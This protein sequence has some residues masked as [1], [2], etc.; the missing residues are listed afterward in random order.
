MVGHLRLRCRCGRALRVA[1][2]RAGTMIRCWDCR[3]TIEAPRPDVRARLADEMREELVA[4]TR[5]PRLIPLLGMAL[6]LAAT[7]TIPRVGPALAAALVIGAVIWARALLRRT[8]GL[9][10]AGTRRYPLTTLG[11]VLVFPLGLVLAEGALVGLTYSQGWLPYMVL[12]LAPRP[13]AEAVFGGRPELTSGNAVD[14]SELPAR[15]ILRVYALG[16]RR[17]HA[18]LGDLPASL[19]HGTTARLDTGYAFLDLFHWQDRVDPTAYLMVRFAYSALILTGVLSLVTLQGRW[20]RRI[21]SVDSRRRAEAMAA[22]EE[23]RRWTELHDWKR[24]PQAPV[25]VFV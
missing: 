1:E 24:G 2:D 12:D 18:L 16:L 23:V 19:R 13:G 4:L 25:P 5:P 3:T 17:G 11:A 9:A 8:V 7:L 6:V 20:L 14:F 15:S 10:L 22:R 21:G